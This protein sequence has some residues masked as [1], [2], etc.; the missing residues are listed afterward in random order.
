MNSR[1]RLLSAPL[2]ALM[3]AACSDTSTGGSVTLNLSA[4]RPSG[5]VASAAFGGAA[6]PTVVTAGDTTMIVLGND[7]IV[8]RSVELVLREIELKRV[9]AAGCDSVAGND[10][11]EEF[12][13]G[14]TL[15]SLPL[16][17]TAIDAVGAR[18][19]PVAVRSG[20]GFQ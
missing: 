3:F 11:C 7:T 19:E 12:E 5:A 9:E 4:V 16:G 2:V 13:T 14:T 18:C 1:T 6:A 8:L 17:T 15:V 20:L 10:D